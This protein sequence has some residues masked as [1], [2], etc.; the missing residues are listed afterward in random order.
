MAFIG[1]RSSRLAPETPGARGGHGRGG[2]TA[3]HCQVG[4]QAEG[5]LKAAE[6]WPV[7]LE[8]NQGTMTWKTGAMWQAGCRAMVP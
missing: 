5:Q 4:S 6:E 8:E 3:R 1:E 7:Q 2:D